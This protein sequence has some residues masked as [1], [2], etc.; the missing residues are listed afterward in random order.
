MNNKTRVSIKFF[1]VAALIILALA[2][3]INGRSLSCEKCTVRFGTEV[4][5][6]VSVFETRII[7]L[8]E[9]YI[10]DS[11]LVAYNKQSGFIKTR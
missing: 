11:C 9:G 5:N 1:C 8:Y 7:D 3:F 6:N 4:F 10:N 2:I